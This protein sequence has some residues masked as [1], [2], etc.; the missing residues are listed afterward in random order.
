MPAETAPDNN[1]TDLNSGV[2]CQFALWPRRVPGIDRSKI[3][4]LS[5]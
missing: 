3:V 1:V 5:D 4:G 2:V